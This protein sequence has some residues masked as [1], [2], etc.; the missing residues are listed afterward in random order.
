MRNRRE[1]TSSSSALVSAASRILVTNTPANGGGCVANCSAYPLLSVLRNHG[2]RG[3]PR[4]TQAW[5]A[6]RELGTQMRSQLSRSLGSGIQ[7][8]DEAQ[9]VWTEE[10]G[11]GQWKGFGSVSGEHWLGNE[12]VYQLTSQRQYALRVELTDWD[13]HQAFS[14]YDRFQI[15]SEKQNY[16]LFLKSHSGTAGRQS[17]LVIH[18]A[19]F[20]TKDMDNDNCMCKCALMMT[21]GWWFDACGPSNLNG[22]YFPQGQHIGKITRS[23]GIISKVLVT[24]SEPPP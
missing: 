18:G 24:L 14:L 12:C 8:I 11:S 5:S 7:T 15:G 9:E 13:G 2:E 3:I 22:V 4:S 6:L 20:S 19:D 23:S 17:S 16:R 21:G 10:R 1:E